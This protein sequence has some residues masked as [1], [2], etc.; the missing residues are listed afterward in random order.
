MHPIVR[1]MRESLSRETRVTYIIQ[2]KRIFAYSG[3]REI[4][5]IERIKY[6]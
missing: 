5:D 2:Q 4:G 3:E 6:T 1:Y